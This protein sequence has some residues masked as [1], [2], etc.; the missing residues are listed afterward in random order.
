MLKF[1]QNMVITWIFARLGL[2][3]CLSCGCVVILLAGL[4]V[5]LL[6]NAILS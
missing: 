4:S 2:R 5:F 3:G 1:F 6:V